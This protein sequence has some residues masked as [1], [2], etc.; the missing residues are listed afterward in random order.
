MDYTNTTTPYELTPT[1]GAVTI[2]VLPVTLSLVRIPKHRLSHFAHPIIK[3]ILSDST[4]S[5]FLNISTNASEVSIIARE[6]DL[7]SFVKIA[8]KDNRRIRRQIQRNVR[9]ESESSAPPSSAPR[10]GQESGAPSPVRPSPRSRRERVL[11]PVEVSSSW[12]ALQIDSHG[13]QLGQYPLPEGK[14]LVFLLIMLWGEPRFFS[15]FGNRSPISPLCQS[16]RRCIRPHSRD[17]VV[18]GGDINLVPVILY[19]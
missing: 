4:S 2:T 15:S 5:T 1:G 9:K 6:Q 10:S 17:I 3:L 16:N 19:N 18:T 14:G 8:R 7:S 11:Q 13:E 12:S